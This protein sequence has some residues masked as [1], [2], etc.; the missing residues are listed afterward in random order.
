MNRWNYLIETEDAEDDGLKDKLKSLFSKS[1][2]LNKFKRHLRPIGTEFG[3]GPGKLEPWEM[4]KSQFTASVSRGNSPSVLMQASDYD[5]LRLV[6]KGWKAI[7]V[8]ERAEFAMKVDPVFRWLIKKNKLKFLK[9]DAASGGSIVYKDK[10]AVAKAYKVAWLKWND[11]F[12]DPT[13]LS[14]QVQGRF[15]GIKEDDINAF[16]NLSHEKLKEIA[17]RNAKH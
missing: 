6:A 7:T 3:P 4:T 11:G 12:G 5:F 9:I 10:I 13:G 14:D 2:R 8:V 16:M 15:F 17:R 1:Y